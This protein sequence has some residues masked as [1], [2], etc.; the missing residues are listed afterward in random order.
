MSKI[1]EN[2]REKSRKSEF[3][4]VSGINVFLFTFVHIQPLSKLYLLELSDEP[5]L[6]FEN[7]E[8]YLKGKNLKLIV[9]FEKV[10]KIHYQTTYILPIYIKLT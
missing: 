8:D 2:R 7:P 9:M 5:F 1:I 6:Q 10:M 3:R 4:Y